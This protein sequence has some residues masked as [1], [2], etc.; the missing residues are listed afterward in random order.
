M[1]VLS[2]E[3]GIYFMQLSFGLFLLLLETP[4]F[5]IPLKVETSVDRGG[6]F[7]TSSKC[8]FF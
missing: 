6:D 8:R 7:I 1:S 2:M 3:E 4:F 5:W